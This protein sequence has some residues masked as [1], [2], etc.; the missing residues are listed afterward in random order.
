MSIR[1]LTRKT[2]ILIAIISCLTS[3]GGDG[4]SGGET[5]ENMTHFLMELATDKTEITNQSSVTLSWSSNYTDGCI[6]SGDWTG[7]KGRGGQE[8]IMIGDAGLKQFSLTCSSASSSDSRNVSVQ[9][10][11]ITLKN[12]PAKVSIFKD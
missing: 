9:V 1:Q 7:G 8:T 3:C 12:V 5:N 2:L 10:S 6:A 11:P 4:R